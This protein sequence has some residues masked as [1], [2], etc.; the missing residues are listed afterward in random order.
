MAEI[1]D[2]LSD[3]ALHM[4]AENKSFDIRYQDVDVMNALAI[5]MHVVSNYSIHRMM[6]KKGTLGENIDFVTSCGHKL[7][8][9]LFETTGIDSKT[10]YQNQK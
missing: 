7:S 9:W 1:L 6:D 4:D 3:A 2:E 10:Y 5:F 8:K